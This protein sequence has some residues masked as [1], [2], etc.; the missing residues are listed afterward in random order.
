LLADGRS[1]AHDF[2]EEVV[3]G[4]VDS[5]MQLA[6]DPFLSDRH[7][8]IKRDGGTF[9]LEDLDSANGT[10]V[11]LTEVRELQP[12]DRIMVGGQILEFVET[13]YPSLSSV[14]KDLGVGDDPWA[15]VETPGPRL[16]HIV[17]GGAA[18]E[19]YPLRPGVTHIGRVAGDLTF[20]DDPLL[21]RKHA[22]IRV[23]E[24][25]AGV[26]DSRPRCTLKD[27]DSRNGVYLQVR[28]RRSLQH[29]DLV[30]LGKQVLRFELAQPS[31]PMRR[32]T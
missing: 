28:G 8:R 29:G 21:S 6:D 2:D 13:S 7:A 12:E 30:A 18:G 4:R 11:R 27:E 20:P 9:Y 5:D 25:P 32:L 14:E 19:V 23:E 16:V 24:T 3:I 26:D 17:E 31:G 22:S 1:E 10:F 15:A